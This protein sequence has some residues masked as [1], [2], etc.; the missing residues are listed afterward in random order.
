MIPTHPLG[1]RHGA[2]VPV[3]G[4]L[5]LCIHGGLRAQPEPPHDPGVLRIG[6]TFHHGGLR[7]TI[8]VAGALAGSFTIAA[9]ETLLG[10]VQIDDR[11]GDGSLYSRA[12]GLDGSYYFELDGQV[13]LDFWPWHP[14]VDQHWFWTDPAATVLHQA[15]SRRQGWPLLWMATASANQASA[16]Q[17][18]GDYVVQSLR[19]SVQGASLT[20]RDVAAVLS[21]DGA[22][23]GTLVGTERQVTT[24]GTAMPQA[25]TLAFAYSIAPDGT[26]V[27]FGGRG[28]VTEDGEMFYL[29]TQDPAQ[30]EFG[31]WIGVKQGHSGDLGDVAG[32]LSVSGISFDQLSLPATP[33]NSSLMGEV[34][35]QAFGP[36]VG[37]ASVS[38]WRAAQAGALPSNPGPL[39][40]ATAIGA[41]RTGSSEVTLVDGELQWTLSFSSNG[42]YWV[43]RELGNPASLL[44]G[45]R[46]TAPCEVIGPAYGSSLPGLGL[47][48]FPQLGNADWG[49]RVNH[50]RGGAPAVLAFAAAP[51]SGWL[52]V[53]QVLWVDP[54]TALATAGFVLGG[55][56]G[57]P[58]VGSAEHSVPVPNQ[59]AFL[60]VSM[61][62]QALVFEPQRA[63]GVAM[64]R[65]LLV[66]IGQ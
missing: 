25:L 57:V 9:D 46:Q 5:A 45:V 61:A 49:L 44:F 39:H 12:Q 19:L 65:G 60:G 23:H 26:L 16:A 11:F 8:G 52:L 59:T 10:T 50:G 21:C 41:V 4:L 47:R 54:A 18:H 3:A 48:G 35:L 32:R 7:G 28:A 6:R 22:G 51:S 58:D 20:T 27:T 40:S 56:P 42:R 1:R 14:G 13:M 55:A 29:V 34:E 66:H 38:G 24:G 64:S 33:R 2:A 37:S 30:Q 43:G 17:L 31:L 36:S 15:P 63:T 62:V 53:D